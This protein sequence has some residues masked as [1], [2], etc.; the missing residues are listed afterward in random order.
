M[1]VK[2]FKSSKLY[3]SISEVA[4]MFDVN[5]SLLRYWEEKFPSITPKKTA[6]G[7]RQ[8]RQQDIEEIKLVYFLVKKRGMTLQGARKQIKDNKEGI[9]K[10]EEVIATLERIKADLNLLK[11]EFD[12][13]DK[14]G[15]L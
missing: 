2:G 14:A 13:L 3:Y 12:A 8:Y 15:E 6:K 5:E 4:A 7:T 1:T 11:S 10:T 9:V